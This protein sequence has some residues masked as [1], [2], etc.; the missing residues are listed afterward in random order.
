MQTNQL[1]EWLLSRGNR[2]QKGNNTMKQ[3]KQVDHKQYEPS[4]WQNV[5]MLLI[6]SL[7]G[8]LAIEGFFG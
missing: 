2:K 3:N 1:T 7:F 5:A 4:G 6:L 8:L